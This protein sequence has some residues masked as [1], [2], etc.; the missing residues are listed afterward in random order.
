MEITR[1]GRQQMIRDGLAST[2]G[3][4][5]GGCANIMPNRKC[6]RVGFAYLMYISC[7]WC[8]SSTQ[9]SNDFEKCG[10]TV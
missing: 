1:F 5:V 3:S 2:G 7:T 8:F 9:K 4:E 10:L 6:L